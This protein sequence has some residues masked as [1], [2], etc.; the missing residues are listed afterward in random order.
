MPWGYVGSST[1]TGIDPTENSAE[2]LAPVAVERAMPSVQ[3]TARERVYR[4][5]RNGGPTTVG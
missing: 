4:A 3:Y 2:F 1:S 5:L